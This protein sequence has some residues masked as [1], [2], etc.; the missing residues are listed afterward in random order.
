MTSQPQTTKKDDMEDRDELG[1]D[2]EGSVEEELSDLSNKVANLRT[3]VEGE[4]Q[5]RAMLQRELDEQLSALFALYPTTSTIADI[6][7]FQ[8]TL[9]QVEILQEATAPSAAVASYPSAPPPPNPSN[10]TQKQQQ[11]QSIQ[12]QQSR[13]PN[14]D[15]QDKKPA[16][17]ST[18]K[19]AG[20]SDTQPTSTSQESSSMDGLHFGAPRRAVTFPQKLHQLLLEAESRGQSDIVSFICDGEAFCIHDEDAFLEDIVPQYFKLSN[21]KSFKRQLYLY[22]FINL[23][24]PDTASIAFSHPQFSRDHPEYLSTIRRTYDKQPQADYEVKGES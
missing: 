16:A 12:Q 17:A 10:P 2:A 3:S 20:E 4:Q 23:R 18:R 21:I 5:R 24:A 7:G 6:L 15:D 22:G 1:E 9:R 19:I 13:Q 11:Q 8:P 14:D